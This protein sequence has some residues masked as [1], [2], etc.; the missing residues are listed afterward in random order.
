MRTDRYRLVV[1]KDR[2]DPEA[3]PIFVE[4]YDHKT[5]P[6]ESRNIAD[7]KPKLVTKLM[8]QFDQGWKGS[9]PVR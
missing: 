1:W 9:L 8:T 3:K 5:D 4:L 6:T 2:T 7:Q